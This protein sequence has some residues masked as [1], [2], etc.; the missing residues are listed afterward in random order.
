MFHGA[1]GSAGM[2]HGAGCSAGRFHGAGGSAWACCGARLHD[3][4]DSAGACWAHACWAQDCCAGACGDGAG[5]CTA[6]GDAACGDAACGDG[7]F[8]DEG[9][10][11]AAQ[12]EAG[13]PG[14]VTGGN[15]DSGGPEY[16]LA[17][18]DSSSGAPNAPWPRMR[19]PHASQN[20]PGAGAPQPGQILPSLAAPRSGPRCFP[21]PRSRPKP[22]VLL[23]LAPQMSQKSVFAVS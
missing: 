16:T 22:G 13:I 2:S 3:E 17:G 23:T 8:H 4:G 14:L 19:R 12:G 18:G 6:C 15:S 11:A 9:G 10:S 21:A 5:W 20:G 1:C 7:E